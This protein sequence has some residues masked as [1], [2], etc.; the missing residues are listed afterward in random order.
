MLMLERKEGEVIKIGD[1]I[2]IT[3]TE[4]DGKRVKVGIKAPKEL[5][6]ERAKK[7]SP[8]WE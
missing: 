2:Q 4:I 7:K 6:I 5:P 8:S 3:I 1:D